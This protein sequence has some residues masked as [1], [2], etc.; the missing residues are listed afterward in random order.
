M[1]AC[2]GEGRGRKEKKKKKKKERHAFEN[3][4]QKEEM[5][6]KPLH[7]FRLA[8]TLQAGRDASQLA[9]QALGL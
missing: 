6:K 4:N 8:H 3:E 2:E 1:A 9:A 5:K 7:L